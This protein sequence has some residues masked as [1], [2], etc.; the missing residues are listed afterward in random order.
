MGDNY[1]YCDF[2]HEMNPLSLFKL[3]SLNKSYYKIITLDVIHESIIKE[4]NN[5]LF[6]IFGDSLVIFKQ[7]LEQKKAIISG[8]FI[9][10]CILGEYWIDSDIDIFCP[11]NI[12]NN[13]NFLEN[14][15]ITRLNFK[16]KNNYQDN[17]GYNTRVKNFEVI[18]HNDK[19][20]IQIIELFIESNYEKLN[21]HVN[22]TD[23]DICKNMFYVENNVDNIRISALN[24][25]FNKIIKSA[26][27]SGI[28]R[29]QKYYKRGFN[30]VDNIANISHVYVDS[31]LIPNE[32]EILTGDPSI[33]ACYPMSLNGS[34]ITRLSHG[35]Y[36][37]YSTFC[38]SNCRIKNQDHFHYKYSF[39][40]YRFII[41]ENDDSTG[42]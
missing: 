13:F 36:N 24:N 27:N 22:G 2:L 5:R 19:I 32:Y 37:G 40:D 42:Y 26:N 38:H 18:K 4:I 35:L 17:Y 20:K 11:V 28:D 34:I 30:I 33:C 15:L 16:I 41:D 23:F 8:S 12:Y 31:T 29:C 7:L 39:C 3:R 25:I 6:V 10:Q 1:F 14:F 9:L 21:M